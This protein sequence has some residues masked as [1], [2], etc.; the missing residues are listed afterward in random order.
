MTFRNLVRILVARWKLAVTAVLACLIGAAFITAV[1]TR[2][3]EAST[4]VLISFSGASDLNELYNGTLTSQER[5]SSYAEIA[6]GRAVVERAVSQL[7]LQANVDDILSQTKVDFTL[8]SMLLRISVK[9]T[10]P[11][12]AAA[13][14]GAIAEQF[15]AIVPTLGVNPA[16]AAAADRGRDGPPPPPQPVSNDAPQGRAT[17]VEP[18]RVPVEPVSPVPMRN[19]AIGLV[20][21]LLLGIAVA[22]IRENSDRTVR[23]RDGLER[24]SGLPVL[25]ELPGK[26]G[27][28]PKFGTDVDYDDSVRGLAVRLRR[29]IGPEGRRV[30]VAGAVGGEGATTT[31]VHLSL[32]LAEIGEDVLLVEGDSRRPE[33]AAMLNVQS[34]RGLADVLVDTGSASESVEATSFSRLYVLASNS[35]PGS[36][37]LSGSYPAEAVDDLLTDMSSRFDRVVVDGPPVLATV[38]AALLAGATQATVLVVRAGHTRVD[39]VADAVDSLRAA[40]ADVVGL[41]L[42]GAR[43]K[44]RNRAAAQ[45]Y[46]ASASGQA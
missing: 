33:I 10:D 21:G 40:N 46:R 36:T 6:G 29:A 4:T 9:D 13:V 35:R 20:A 23:N 15:G 2:V 11:E 31:A 16:P 37:S 22:V 7:Q 17:I 26:R 28:A 42:T 18:P 12:R 24:V 32:V 38:D 44:M 14:V 43:S 1:Q 41:I 34:G 8:D 45:N 3:Y 25:T 39:D 19:L 27:R 5:L 30:L